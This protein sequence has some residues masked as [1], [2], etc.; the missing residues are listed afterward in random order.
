LTVHHDP[1]APPLPAVAGWSPEVAVKLVVIATP[2]YGGLVTLDYLYSFMDACDALRARGV[3]S[4]LVTTGGESLIQRARNIMC[5]R[6]LA[7]PDASHL[8]FIDADLKF[9]G[10]AVI[11][12]LCHDRDIVC[13]VY[14]LK[15]LPIEY[16]FHP[17]LDKHGHTRRDPVSGAIEIEHGST[18]FMCIKR[19]VL[20][21]LSLAYWEE[22]FRAPVG[23]GLTP[24]EE[25][26]LFNFFPV[27]VDEEILWSEDYGFCKRWRAL[28]GE[29]WMDPAIT[30]SHRGSFLYRGDPSRIYGIVR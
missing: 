28:G 26:W 1:A 10:E 23:S 16:A 14:P 2:A 18:G 19:T 11:R 27:T 20:E 30:L 8:I 22:K 12:L 29:V 21:Q 13:G 3:A 6:F 25:R 9:D 4:M 24:E 15:T 7:L 17:L 5:A